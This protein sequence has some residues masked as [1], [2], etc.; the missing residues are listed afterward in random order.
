M[1]CLDSKISKGEQQN[2]SQYIIPTFG[3]LL[4]WG[5]VYFSEYPSS[6][7]GP[8]K[9]LF[10]SATPALFLKLLFTIILGLS[11]LFP[12]FTNPTCFC[13]RDYCLRVWRQELPGKRCMAGNIFESWQVWKYLDSTITPPD[14]L[15]RIVSIA[16]DFFFSSE[17][18]RHISAAF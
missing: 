7:L 5:G 15:A 17:F 4:I 1:T 14:G 18:W 13:F 8:Y 9:L 11:S 3:C 10:R 16:W 2:F 12:Y 6:C